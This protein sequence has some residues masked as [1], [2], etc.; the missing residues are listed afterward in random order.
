M[1]SLK[2][3]II[4]GIFDDEIAISKQTDKSIINSIKEWAKTHIAKK[5]GRMKSYVGDNGDYILEYTGVEDLEINFSDI[6]DIVK[7]KAN[8][9]RNTYLSRVEDGFMEKFVDSEFNNLLIN[10]GSA[11]FIGNV[12][13][14]TIN[15]LHLDLDDCPNMTDFSSFKNCNIYYLIVSCHNFNK[16][17]INFDGLNIKNELKFNGYY[18]Y[19]GKN[20]HELTVTGKYDADDITIQ[21]LKIQGLP[22]KIPG[23]LRDNA[24]LSWWNNDI[25]SIGEKFVFSVSKELF[26]EVYDIVTSKNIKLPKFNKAQIDVVGIGYVFNNPKE[27]SIAMQAGYMRLV[28]KYHFEN[29][30]MYPEF[31]SHMLQFKNNIEGEYTLK[32]WLDKKGYKLINDYDLKPTNMRRK[33]HEQSSRTFH[34]LDKNDKIV[35]TYHPLLSIHDNP[36]YIISTDKNIIDEIKNIKCYHY[37]TTY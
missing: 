35:A 20:T 6:P 11:K 31:K 23:T 34:I 3:Y 7:I 25:K 26:K 1:I 15:A 19:T 33:L 28:N 29:S 32:Y 18:G 22:Q 21:F 12:Q 4:E 8:N 5:K 17:S 30:Q 27:L 10:S 36:P 14:C 9:P 24:G 37:Q 2:D 16:H 13:P